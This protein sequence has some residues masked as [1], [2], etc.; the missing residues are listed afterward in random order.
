MAQRATERTAE[1]QPARARSNPKS[2]SEADGVVKHSKRDWE[3][4][5]GG[6][7]DQLHKNN[8]LYYSDRHLCCTGVRDKHNYLMIFLLKSIWDKERECSAI[9][10]RKPVSSRGHYPSEKKAL[11]AACWSR[12]NLLLRALVCRSPEGFPPPCWTIWLFSFATCSSE[13]WETT[14]R[15]T[16]GTC[17]G[18]SLVLKSLR[19]LL[20]WPG[21]KLIPPDLGPQKNCPQARLAKDY[22][23][24]FNLSY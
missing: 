17:S 12:M 1:W 19:F 18:I 4:L 2:P 3:V 14:P 9:L 8:S 22:W 5:F 13:T 16:G 21:S 20:R 7:Q 15:T 23:Y 6:S 24:Y 10:K 11:T